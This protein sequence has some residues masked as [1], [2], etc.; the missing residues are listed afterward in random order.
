[1]KKKRWIITSIIILIVLVIIGIITFKILTNEN[2]LTSEER[3]WINENINNVQNIYVI[4]DQNVF[5]KDGNG[6]FY[7]FL[8]DFSEEYGININTVSFGKE[9]TLKDINL[10]YTK[11]IDDKSKIFYTDHYVLVSNNYEVINSNK[12]LENKTIGVLNSELDYIK[13]YLK[14]VNISFNGYETEKDLFESIGTNVNYIILPRIEYIDKILSNDLEI[15]Y[16]LSDINSYYTLNSNDTVFSSILNK[17]FVKWEDKLEES[18][19]KEEFN[20]FTESLAISETE[21][22]K[23][24]SIDYKYGF[25]NNSPYEVIMS[26]NYGGIIAEYLQEFSEFSGVYFDI[27]K[28]KNMNKLV[29]A[30]NKDKVD[31]Y[32]AFNDN[33]ESDYKVT[34]HGINSSLS[35]LTTYDNEKIINSIYGL[36]GETVYVEEN[37][38]LET[39]L[40]SIKGI[41]NI[42]IKT[43]KTSKEL[44]KLNK[45]DTIIV[46]DTYI[47]E[48]YSDSKLNNYVSKYDNFINNKYTFKVNKDYNTLYKLLDKYISYLDNSSM[49]NQGINSH[50]ETVENGN[51]L[52]NIAKYFIISL[53]AILL[54]GLIIYKNSKKVRI[55]KRIKNSD[56]IRFIDELTCLKNRN[57]L[58]DFIKTWSNNTIYPQAVIVMDLNKLKDINDKFGV[59]EG[60]KQIQAAANALIKTQLDNSDLMRSDGNEFVIY[61]VGYNQKQIINYIHKLNKELKKLPYNFG[62]EFGYSIIESN[63]KTVEDALS[64]AIEDMKNKKASVTK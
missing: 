14:E 42:N 29:D 3:T 47:Y 52:N 28:Y 53:V 55:A 20:I 41:E 25:I 36:Q 64:E 54:I 1:M 60:D 58:S 12:D 18:I 57:Y 27:T 50:I 26:G 21:V 37:S 46:M 39:Y 48:Y 30:I 8:N 38:N 6:V 13:K 5:S 9:E 62:A 23:L 45:E 7:T 51:V 4:K 49:I 17:Y 56:K 35:I 33:I 2:K 11:S 10:N 31:L 61:T 16:H 63:L 32:F 15:I 19:K 40:K 59:I 34:K 43:Y 22:D 44:F 24:L